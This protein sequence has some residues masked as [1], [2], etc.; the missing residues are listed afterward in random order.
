MPHEAYHAS[1]KR[2]LTA[3]H[4]DGRCP[5]CGSEDW[6]ISDP[7]YPIVE[8]V[9]ASCGHTVITDAANAVDA[10]DDVAGTS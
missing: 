10:T 2:W 3:R 7:D 1:V 5:K 6:N 4:G 9:C 8:C